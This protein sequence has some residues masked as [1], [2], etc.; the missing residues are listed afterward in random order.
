[1]SVFYLIY[2]STL[3]VTIVLGIMTWKIEGGNKTRHRKI[4]RSK[5]KL[6]IDTTE[7]DLYGL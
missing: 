3:V 1:M 7:I 6:L 5:P 2:I 4:K